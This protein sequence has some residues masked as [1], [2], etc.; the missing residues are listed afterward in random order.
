[1]KKGL[2]FL[3]ISLFCVFLL[4]CA[5]CSPEK[6]V[7]IQKHFSSNIYV[8]TED[9]SFKGEFS[10]NKRG[11]IILTVNF[12]EE[13]AGYK[14]TVKDKSVKMSFMDID[15]SYNIT[16]FPQKAP[17]RVLYQVLKFLETQNNVINQR[18]DNESNRYNIKTEDSIVY[19]NSKGEITSIKNDSVEITFVNPVAENK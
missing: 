1:M 15:S 19:I 5:G 13:I 7:V 18:G 4:P 6:Q 2:F 9:I 10:H 8:S 11:D 12:P 17:I 3:F 14:Y 16:D